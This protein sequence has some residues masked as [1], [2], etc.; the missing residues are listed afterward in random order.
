MVISRKKHHI[1]TP[2]MQRMRFPWKRNQ[3]TNIIVY[4]ISRSNSNFEIYESLPPRGR[5]GEAAG[6][7]LR[8]RGTFTGEEIDVL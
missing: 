1:L 7:S 8:A 5:S 2:R 6:G 4:Y 3:S